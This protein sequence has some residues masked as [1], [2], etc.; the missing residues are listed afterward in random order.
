[1]S[2]LWIFLG[3][4][5]LIILHEAGHFFAAKWT[6]MRVE[7]FFLF[8]GPKIASVKRGETEYGIA[9]IPAGGYVKISGMNPDDVLPEGEE[10]RGYYEMPVWK[11]I[12]VIGAGP[13]VN[14]VLAFAILFVVLMTSA[15]VADQRVE[16]V[17]PKTAASGVL[18]PGDRI[19]AVDGK[20]FAGAEPE[21]RVDSFRDQVNNHTCAGVQKDGCRSATAARL[22]IERDGRVRTVS[23]H[24]EY[25]A[26]ADRALVGFG[27]GSVPTTISA[28]EAVDRSTGFMWEISTKT[29]TVFANLLDPEKRKEVSGVVG[30]SEVAHQ[31]IDKFGA[32]EALVLLAIVSL[33]LGLINLFPFLPLDGGHIF[34]SLVEKV[35]GKPVP[36]R[37]MERAGAIGFVLVIMLFF[38]GLSNDIG[39]L[40]GEGFNVR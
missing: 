24:P 16:E 21:S 19:V 13:A 6:G 14:I 34:W 15:R 9:A 12:V 35:R 1:M 2:W 30:T 31:T 8:F 28:G 17:F 10:H 36:F 23:V 20:R 26:A 3:F 37:V 4:S 25:S 32:T 22:T 18:K 5:A 7:K 38:L 39:R 40:T 27:F 33:S 11:R 29:V